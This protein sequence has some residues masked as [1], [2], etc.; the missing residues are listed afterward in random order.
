MID[1]K[2]KHLRPSDFKRDCGV[3]RAVFL[4]MVDAVRPKL[5]VKANAGDSL[6][7]GSKPNCWSPSNIGANAALSFI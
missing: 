2:L 1:D 7:A 3:R 6:N 4:K 5:G